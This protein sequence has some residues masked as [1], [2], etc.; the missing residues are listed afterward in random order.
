MPYLRYF[1]QFYSDAL[2]TMEPEFDL[3][4]RGQIYFSAP[5]FVFGGRP[6]PLC[7]TFFANDLSDFID[8]SG[9]SGQ[10]VAVNRIMNLIIALF[11]DALFNKPSVAFL[12]PLSSP[13]LLCARKRAQSIVR[14][15]LSAKR[16]A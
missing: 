11:G 9:I 13:P 10:L 1:I 14:M 8:K 5:M 4:K 7:S 2:S 12:P 16:V 6:G 15:C 3:Q